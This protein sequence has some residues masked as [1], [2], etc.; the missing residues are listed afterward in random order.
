MDGAG[1]AAGIVTLLADPV[2]AREMGQRGRA[3]I[4][5]L[6]SYPVI[7]E[8]LAATYRLLLTPTDA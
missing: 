8:R 1:F 4:A 3:A 6:R 5:A 7:A 2:A